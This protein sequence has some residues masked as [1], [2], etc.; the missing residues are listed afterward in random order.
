MF[1]IVFFQYI[2]FICVLFFSPLSAVHFL[3]SVLVTEPADPKPADLASGRG[4]PNT[5]WPRAATMAS[6]GQGGPEVVLHWPSGF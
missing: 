3:I 1:S 4:P 5:R 2:Q 6:C